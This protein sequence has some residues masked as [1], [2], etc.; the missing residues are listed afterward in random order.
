MV[1]YVRLTITR[2]V[3]VEGD[4]DEELRLLA[5]EGKGAVVDERIRRADVLRKD[6]K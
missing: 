4:T 1:G 6:T 3:R 5:L 2:D